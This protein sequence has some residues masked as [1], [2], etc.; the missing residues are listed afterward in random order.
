MEA[1]AC[2][3]SAVAPCAFPTARL[4]PGASPLPG[5]VAALTTASII[6]KYSSVRLALGLRS[7]SASVAGTPLRWV[8]QT[9]RQNV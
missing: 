7:V 8:W 9:A 2:S 6:L 4:V 1:Q 3:S 5:P